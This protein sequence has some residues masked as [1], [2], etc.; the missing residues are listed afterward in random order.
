M[1]ALTKNPGG[2]AGADSVLVG[3]EQDRLGEFNLQA[4]A[5]AAK[6]SLPSHMARC[7]LCLLRGDVW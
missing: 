4:Q 5:L 6:F 7:V 2:E 1:E 3:T